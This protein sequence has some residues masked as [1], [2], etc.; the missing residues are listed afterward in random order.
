MGQGLRRRRLYEGAHPSRLRRSAYGTHQETVTGSRNFRIHHQAGQRAHRGA[1]LCEEAAR[2]APH[3]GRGEVQHH[4]VSHGGKGRQK[5]ARGD[6]RNGA[7]R[8]D[9]RGDRLDPQGRVLCRAVC[10]EPVLRAARSGAGAADGSARHAR[11]TGARTKRGRDGGGALQGGLRRR[12]VSELGGGLCGPQAR[13]CSEQ[14]GRR[15]FVDA[16]GSQGRI[17]RAGQGARGCGDLPQL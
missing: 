16:G 3:Q 6:R 15:R 13:A 11:R 2:H 5:A 8:H 17:R 12:R 4:R 14:R 7:R 9:G 10:N 1:V